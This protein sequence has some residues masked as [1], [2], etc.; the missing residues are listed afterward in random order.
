MLRRARG[1][2]WRLR[3]VGTVNSLS[4]HGTALRN[5]FDPRLPGGG[6][7]RRSFRR[8]AVVGARLRRRSFGSGVRRDGH[9]SFSATLAAPIPSSAKVPTDWD[10]LLWSFCRRRQLFRPVRFSVRGHDGRPVRIQRHGALLG[11]GKGRPC[12]N[13][14]PE[15]NTP[16]PPAVGWLTPARWTSSEPSPSSLV[17]GRPR[18]RFSEERGSPL[19][20]G[21]VA[22]GGRSGNRLWSNLRRELAEPLFAGRA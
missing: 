11:H 21:K 13:V 2:A 7:D 14:E 12:T 4:G 15:S 18:T 1:F 6:P 10:A 19:R 8:R 3:R 9:F 17:G 5:F 16:A 22:V 20:S